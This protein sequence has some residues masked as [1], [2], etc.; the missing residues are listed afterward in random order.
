M[1]KKKA[2]EVTEMEIARNRNEEY[3]EEVCKGNERKGKLGEARGIEWG[4]LPCCYTRSNERATLAARLARGLRYPISAWPAMSHRA[5]E[6]E[7]DWGEVEKALLRLLTCLVGSCQG[8]V[9]A[10]SKLFAQPTITRY[11]LCT[12]RLSVKLAHLGG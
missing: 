12:T 10:T 7:W 11:S 6:W 3:R 2:M 1:M 8:K 5:W 9:L 4:N